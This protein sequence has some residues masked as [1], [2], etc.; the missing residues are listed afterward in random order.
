MKKNFDELES[1][2]YKEL[3]NVGDSIEE[4]VFIQNDPFLTFLIKHLYLIFYPYSI[5]RIR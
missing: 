3:V 1:L 5:Y 4:T 2:Y